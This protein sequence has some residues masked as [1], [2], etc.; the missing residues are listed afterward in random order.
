MTDQYENMPASDRQSLI[1]KMFVSHDRFELAFTGIERFHFP[2]T[3]GSP[4]AGALGLLMGDTRTGKSYA[5][6]R[7]AKK[8]PHVDGPAGKIIPVAVAYMPIEGGAAG[9]LH[10]ISSAI[11]VQYS[12]RMS[13]EHLKECLK[14]A[15]V[16][17]GV[18]LLIL[19]ECE[20]VVRS[21]KKGYIVYFKDMLRKLLDIG[22]FSI[23]CIGLEEV[24]DELNDDPRLVGRGL[25]PY[26]HL[27]P[28]RWQ[29]EA[30]RRQFRLICAGFD[31]LLPFASQSGLSENE[32]AQRLHWVSEGRIGHLKQM[33]KYAAYNA[34]NDG[35]ASVEKSHFIDA[36]ERIKPWGTSF[37]AFEDDLSRAPDNARGDAV[38]DKPKNLG[39]SAFQK[40]QREWAKHAST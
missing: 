30:D 12:K 15:L 20:Q 1:D 10:A 8:H 37:N 3:G 32:F 23:L 2:V 16:A 36:Y 4:A 24:Y 11:G 38:F 18:Q 34:L 6:Q 33:L 5:G 14:R 13:N 22:S 7:Y 35:A 25:L 27:E 29:S 9:L 17:R 39:L 19:D 31:K 21:S 40:T 28:Y 26:T